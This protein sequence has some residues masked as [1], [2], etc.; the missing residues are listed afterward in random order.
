MDFCIDKLNCQPPLDIIE[1][2]P[3]FE[4]IEPLDYLTHQ[5]DIIAELNINRSYDDLLDVSTTYLGTEIVQ[6]TDVFNAQPTFPITLD[7]HTNGE[8]L[9]G[10][11]LDI[12]LD[13]GTSKSYMSK[14]NYMRHPHLHHF[15]K[16]QSAIR[17]FLKSDHMVLLEHLLKTLILHSLKLSHRKCQLFMKHLVYLG[18]VF[19]IENGVI[20][21]THMKNR[22]EAI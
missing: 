1:N 11:K 15:P 10:G 2:P 4:G 7:C 9:G 21:I 19:H 17:H 12:L 18:N 3:N 16:F 20:T 13:T 14:A 22:I 8:L 6:W 5:P